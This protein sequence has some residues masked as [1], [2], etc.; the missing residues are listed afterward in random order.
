MSHRICA[1]HFNLFGKGRVKPAFVDRLNDS[2]YKI[3]I[4]GKPGAILA[5]IKIDNPSKLA[6]KM[7]AFMCLSFFQPFVITYLHIRGG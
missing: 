7:V 5:P 2:V 1:R 6:L 4:E 3:D